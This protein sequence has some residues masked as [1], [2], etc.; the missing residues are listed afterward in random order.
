MYQHC[1]LKKKELIDNINFNVDNKKNVG[2]STII[3]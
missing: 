3:S 1:H 2:L